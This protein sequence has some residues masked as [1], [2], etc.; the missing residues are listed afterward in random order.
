MSRAL[1]H[2][3]DKDWAVRSEQCRTGSASQSASDGPY[4]Q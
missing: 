1:T 2:H 3:L 4:S